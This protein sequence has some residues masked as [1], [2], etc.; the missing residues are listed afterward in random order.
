[1]MTGVLVLL[2]ATAR[3]WPFSQKHAIAAVMLTVAVPV[4]ACMVV[5]FALDI[6]AR[7][8]KRAAS[9]SRSP[10]NVS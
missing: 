7:E 1:M 6:K 9:A 10:T 8:A 2:F 4:V 3:N 5:G